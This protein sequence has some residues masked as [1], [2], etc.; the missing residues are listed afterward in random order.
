[1]CFFD[2]E[3]RPNLLSHTLFMFVSGGLLQPGQPL[4]VFLPARNKY[5]FTLAFF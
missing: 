1:M 2:D 5:L 3:L 4:G